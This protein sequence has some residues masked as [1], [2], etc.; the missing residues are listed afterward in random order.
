M[1]IAGMTGEY[2][3]P[4]IGQI[5]KG[6]AKPDEKRP[7]KD[8]GE[9]LR[10][11]GADEAIT[12]D[13]VATFGDTKVDELIVRLAFPTVDENWAAWMESWVAGGLVRRCDRRNVVLSLQN[14]GTYDDTP[15][16]CTGRC[17]CKPVGRLAMFVP[18]FQRLGT[19]TLHTTSI[20]DIMNL[21]GCIR[22]LAM[23]VGDLT[24]VPFTLKRVPRD[25]STPAKDGRRARRQVWLLHLEPSPEWVRA[26]AAGGQALAALA[27]TE[28]LALPGPS[29]NGLPDAVDATTGE[30]LTG[31]ATAVKNGFRARIEAADSLEALHA[32]WPDIQAIEEATYK[33]NV[34]ALCRA[35]SVEIIRGLIAQAQPDELDRLSQ[36]L[37]ALPDVTPG[38][39]VAVAE[40]EARI[41]ADEPAAD[42]AVAVDQVAEEV[43]A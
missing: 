5:R 31:D 6:E 18:A 2:R 7:G 39:A 41:W 37:D 10:F 25:I 23:L 11:V 9:E 36:K 33:A 12:A 13:W 40:L 32:L 38:K 3:W 42:E 21:D 1:P 24:R 19:V 28:T 20:H 43:A 22:S 34:I 17:D 35:R 4:R 8:L 15:R 16:P 29:T 14:D 27:T 26:I 30:V